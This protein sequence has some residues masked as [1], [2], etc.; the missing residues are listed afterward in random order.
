MGIDREI[1]TAELK[2]GCEAFEIELNDTQ[3]QD[4]CKYAEILVEL[5]GTR[6]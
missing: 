3:I 2:K 1:L 5:S 4:F 6:K